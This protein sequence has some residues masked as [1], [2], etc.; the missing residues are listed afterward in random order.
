M[1]AGFWK[2]MAAYLIASTYVV[3]KLNYMNENGNKI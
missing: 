2:R 3:N 1:Q